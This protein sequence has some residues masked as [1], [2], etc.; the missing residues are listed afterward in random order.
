MPEHAYRGTAIELFSHPELLK[1]SN[2]KARKATE[3]STLDKGTHV[4]IKMHSAVA[5]QVEGTS[6]LA[7]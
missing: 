7:Y 2:R 4:A 5:D 3:N 6:N 1:T